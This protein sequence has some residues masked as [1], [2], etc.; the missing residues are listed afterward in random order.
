MGSGT[1]STDVYSAAASYRRA[2]GKSAFD[3]SDSGARKVH[4]ALDPRGE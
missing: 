2:S 1:W 4:P 3:Y